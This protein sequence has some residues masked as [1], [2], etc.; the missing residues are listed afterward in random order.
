MI[1]RY[2]GICK[3]KKGEKWEEE[4]KEEEEGEER[5]EGKG[6]ILPSLF[7]LFLTNKH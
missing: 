7:K 1:K 2:E 4:E 5:E 6:K 3:K